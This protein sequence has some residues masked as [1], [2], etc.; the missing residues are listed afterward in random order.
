MKI[1]ILGLGVLGRGVGVAEFLARKEADLVITDLKG[2]ADLKSSLVRLRKYRGIKYVLGRHRISDFRKRDLII[3]AAGVPLDS[4]YIKKAKK[5]KIP[6]EMDASLFAKLSGARII[7]VTGS[8]GKSTVVQLL[9]EILKKSGREVF[10]GGNVRGLATLPL[11][12]KVKKGDL[13]LMELDSWQLQGFGEAKI[14]PSVSVFTNFLDDHLNYYKG[15]RKKYF[16]DKANIFRYQGEDDYLII[17]RQARESV[18][19]YFKGK[20]ESKILLV[21]DSGLPSGWKTRT[22]GEH[23]LRNAAFA[24][25]TARVLGVK[26]SVI[27]GVV[28]KFRGAP[29]RL[30]FVRRV[31]GAEYYNDTTAT[32]PEAAIAALKFF[33]P[34]RTNKPRVILIAGGADKCLDYKNFVGELRGRVK[35][36]ILFSG[37]ATDKITRGIKRV[38]FDCERGIKKVDNMKDALKLA[39]TCVKKEDIVLLSPGAASFGVFK[40]EFDRGAQFCEAVRGL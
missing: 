34:T 7:G 30:E 25:M 27:K 31:D 23:N 29:G 22:L 28:E 13:V 10:L 12:E 14:S 18:K 26:G 17:S 9:Y 24:I 19:K 39:R 20:I 16:N 3:K 36:L 2:V 37:A 1:T 35:A 38:K 40:N 21:G 15:D 6:V 8:K 5:N 33:A 4:I 11:L 32:M